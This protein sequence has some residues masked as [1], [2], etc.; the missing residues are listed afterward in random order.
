MVV[1]DQPEAFDPKAW[2]L[3]VRAVH[4]ECLAAAV[5]LRLTDEFVR[6][7]RGWSTIYRI[8]GDRMLVLEWEQ[9][10]DWSKSRGALLHDYLWWPR[11]TRLTYRRRLREL[12]KQFN[13]FIEE[14]KQRHAPRVGSQADAG[15]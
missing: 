12:D 11:R 4:I 10:N 3:A 15:A 8:K 7:A 9:L 6:A 2:E 14:A 13:A 1:L 5:P